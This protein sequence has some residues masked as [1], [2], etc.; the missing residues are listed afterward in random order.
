VRRA[1]GRVR[2]SVAVTLN[3]LLP[4]CHILFQH[5]NRKE[6]SCSLTRCVLLNNAY[7]MVSTWNCIQRSSFGF[8]MVCRFAYRITTNM[9]N[10]RTFTNILRTG[11]T[12]GMVLLPYVAML[13]NAVAW[14]TYGILA[15]DA[16]TVVVSCLQIVCGVRYVTIFVTHTVDR[17]S[18]YRILLSAGAVLVIFGLVGIVSPAASRLGRLGALAGLA[19]LLMFLA[20]LR[21]VSNLIDKQDTN[22]IPTSL[23]L[24]NSATASMWA[25]HGLVNHDLW[26]AIPPLIGAIC[27]C[28]VLGLILLLRIRQRSFI[29]QLPAITI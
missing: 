24:L 17:V 29:H 25:A 27:M 8:A 10:R 22:N 4:A 2:I 23:L 21:R 19:S 13:I 9:R 12:D 11:A 5:R 7:N 3:L 16:A 28:A 1:E 14:L 20:P 18:A 15:V 26:I 6:F